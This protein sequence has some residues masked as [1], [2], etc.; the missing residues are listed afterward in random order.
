[1]FLTH[2]LFLHS[3]VEG[4]LSAFFTSVGLKKKGESLRMNWQA[5]PGCKGRLKLGIRNYQKDGENR[6][7]NEIKQFYPKETSK[8]TAG[9]F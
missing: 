2:N 8:Y 5:V 4:L 3:R 6:T 7:I 9:K 1:M